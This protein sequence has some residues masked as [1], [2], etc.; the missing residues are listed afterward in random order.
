[1]L[2]ETRNVLCAAA[3]ATCAM[4]TA[5]SAVGATVELVTNGGFEDG[6]TGFT[7]DFVNVS[8]GF[9]GLAQVSVMTG[10]YFGLTAHTGNAFF[11]VNGGNVQGALP[12]VWSQN[13]SLV[14]GV[15]YTL[16][17]QLGGTSV[18][19]VPVGQLSVQIGGTELLKASAPEGPT[20]LSY[21]TTFTATG[22]G[23]FA[24]EFVEE[25]F[26]FGGNDYGLDEISLTFQGQPAS[27]I[28]LPAAGLMLLSAVGGFA[29]LRRRKGTA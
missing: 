2:K 19:P 3:C 24:L 16:S 10:N 21:G 7:S 1:M 18:A 23:V 8:G 17:F 11:A 5:T 20:Y 25:S 9:P 12:T 22:T 6:N 26:A 4:M 29:M 15:D 13:V 28:P 14:S 27:P